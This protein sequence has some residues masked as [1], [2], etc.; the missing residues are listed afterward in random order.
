[1]EDAFCLFWV[2]GSQPGKILKDR[3]PSPTRHAPFFFQMLYHV[4]FS[5]CIFENTLLKLYQNLPVNMSHHYPS[6]I[7]IETYRNIWSWST[8][9]VCLCVCVCLFVCLLFL[10]FCLFVAVFFFFLGGVFEVAFLL[11]PLKCLSVFEVAF[12]LTPVK[13]L[14]VTTKYM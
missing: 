12:L 8:L 2:C 7:D 5:F 4:E 14:S 6:S 3:P 11:T 9:C 1:M 13:C 10:F